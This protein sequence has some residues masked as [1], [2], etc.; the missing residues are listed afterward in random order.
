MVIFLG[1]RTDV[2][3]GNESVPRFELVGQGEGRD[4]F[5]GEIC[6]VGGI[7]RT[8]SDR[9]DNNRQEVV[10]KTTTYRV[11]R[12]ASSAGYCACCCK[13]HLLV[14]K[15]KKGGGGGLFVVGNTS[16]TYVY[17]LVKKTQKIWLGGH[18]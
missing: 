17:F 6:V 18:N 3:W 12:T 13:K 14:I 2:F 15:E 4:Q 16:T 9:F 10:R 7:D 8:I 1:W 5:I 11:P